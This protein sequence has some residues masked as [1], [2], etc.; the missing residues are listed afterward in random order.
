MPFPGGAVEALQ[1]I[2]MSW[3]D[4]LATP[5]HPR[6]E[7]VDGVVVVSPD[8][9]WR[10][11]RVARKLAN[12]FDE[13]DGLYGS[14]S[15]NIKLP[16]NRVRIPDAYA[17]TKP[18]GLFIEQPVLVVEVL[19]Q[20]T[21]SEDL[22]RKAPEYAA[23]GI[24]QY[25]IVDPEHRTLEVQTLVEGRWELFVRLDDHTPTGQVAIGDHG[26]V[27]IDLLDLLDG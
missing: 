18:E 21:R 20:S 14:T 25:W 15:G 16:H 5:E 26:V 4:Y 17:T 9:V 22:L 10:H 23:A 24:E 13:V 27:R 8:P 3:E 1:R 6:H 2:P 7:W 11:Q 12:V 19:S